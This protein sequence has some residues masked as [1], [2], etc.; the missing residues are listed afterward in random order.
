[1]L[2]DFAGNK[3]SKRHTF[4]VLINGE[5][6][7]CYSVIISGRNFLFPPFK[8]KFTPVGHSFSD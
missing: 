4:I 8:R 2:V 6:S 1:M 3:L 5:K 7:M